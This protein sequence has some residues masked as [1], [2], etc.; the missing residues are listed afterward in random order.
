MARL[1]PCW[2]V[3][4]G[5]NN[6]PVAQDTIDFTPAYTYWQE[7]ED[8]W[9]MSAQPGQKH[10]DTGGIVFG[11]RYVD[12]MPIYRRAVR[13]ADQSSTGQLDPGKVEI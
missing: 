12:G 9:A 2:C 5:F 8:Y 11:H 4:F 1:K 7:T 13:L 10:F 6:L 3:S